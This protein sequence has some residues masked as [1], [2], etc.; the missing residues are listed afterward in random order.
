M[1]QE[2]L[3]ISDVATL[4]ALSSPVR[5]RILGL[6]RNGDKRTVGQISAQTGIAPGSASYHLQKLEEVGLV[7]RVDYDEGDHRQ[8]WWET[9]RAVIEPNPDTDAASGLEAE[10]AIRRASAQSYAN[11]Y[12]RYLNSYETIPRE[13]R[14]SEIGFDSVLSLT[15]SELKSLQ[16][17]L[18][19]VLDTWRQKS[20]NR[21]EE[22]ESRSEKDG[23]ERV[24]V[25]V[26]GFVWSP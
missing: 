12:G 6:L 17:E 3:K 18:G 7:R 8:S 11:A 20:C 25:I 24:L 26:S 10:V 1:E 13:W 16:T 21:S 22:A 15:P 9:S 2:I 4:K 23:D 14:D 19:D 5:M